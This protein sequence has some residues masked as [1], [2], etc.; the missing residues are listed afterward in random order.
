MLKKPFSGG[1]GEVKM[2]LS[3]LVENPAWEIA[4]DIVVDLFFTLFNYLLQIIFTAGFQLL[5][6]IIN[7]TKFTN[8]AGIMLAGVFLFTGLMLLRK[9]GMW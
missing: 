9:N 3:I 8:V 1:Y 5:D 6:G 4:E 2:N 7:S